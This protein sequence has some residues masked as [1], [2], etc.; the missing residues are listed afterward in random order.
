MEKIS[1]AQR[2]LLIGQA[3]GPNT[4]PDLPLFPVP[5][6][7]AGG[8]LRAMIGITRGEYL[9]SFDR[10]NVFREFPGRHMNNDKFPMAEARIR[11]EA[12]LPFLAGR[13]VVLAGR[14]VADAFKIKGD[15]F[16]WQ[17]VKARRVEHMKRC[18]GLAKVAIIP[19]PSGRNKFYNTRENQILARD[20]WNSFKINHLPHLS[21]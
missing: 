12:M 1:H 5:S 13:V 11:A 8:R 6:T 16:T 20:F 3:P 9:K 14:Q 19:H 21:S 10:V 17:D 7:S 4:M 15:F 2:P 18:N